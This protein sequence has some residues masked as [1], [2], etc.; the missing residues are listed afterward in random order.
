MPRAP[1]SLENEDE[2]YSD[3][4]SLS[5]LTAKAGSKKV[6]STDVRAAV[7]GKKHHKPLKKVY[8]NVEKKN[9]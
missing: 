3:E 2:E 4:E 6:T 5:F 1:P 9:V 7:S 8:S